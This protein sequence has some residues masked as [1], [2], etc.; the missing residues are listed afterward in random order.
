MSFDF[1]RNNLLWRKDDDGKTPKRAYHI[2]DDFLRLPVTFY[3]SVGID[4]YNSG[5]N[6]GL[7]FRLYFA[8]NW[9][10]TVFTVILEIMFFSTIVSDDEKFLE[11]CITL[12]YLSFVIV[13]FLKLISV[14]TKKKKLTSL[15]R[16]LESCFPSP[17]A[18]DQEQYA[19]KTFLKRC[20]IFTMGFGV[21]LT[22][23]CLAHILIPLVIYYFQRWVLNSLD[24]ERELPFF[25]LAPWDYSGYM[26]YPTYFLQSI[27][28]YTVTC[29]AI[30]NDIMIFAVVFQVLMHYD[31]L[32][33]VLR[34]FK[35]RNHNESEGAEEDLKAL[36]SLVANHIDILRLTDVMNDVF[37][38]P[39]LLNF[40]VSSLLVCLVGFQL[41]I[42]FSPAY[43]GKQ[44]LL[45]ASAI[46]E[47]YLLCSFSQMLID[48]SGKI[49]LAAY[50]MNWIEADMRCR[51]MLIFLS[52][53]AQKPV[54]LKATVVLDLSN[55][56]MSIFLGMSYRFFCALRTM[57]P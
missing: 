31:R 4:P 20:K 9:I 25:G 26:F 27:A 50:E 40:L 21:L 36:R 22:T 17:S 46:V 54:C 28:A 15:V 29:G 47:V 48:A 13:G 8:L 39:L 35:V 24:L 32:S 1:L 55:E 37:G 43:F 2:V 30:S 11:S 23:M 44:V 53:R 56:T 57:Y 52:L 34:E 3:N 45:L 41:T 5:Q 18:S 10:N 7:W 12:G 51:K 19:V 14:L 33:R 49:S 6:H 38:V 42:E 16:H